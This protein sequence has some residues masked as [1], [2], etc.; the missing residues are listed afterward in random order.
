MVSISKQ[1]VIDNCISVK[2]AAKYSGYS[3]QYIRRLLRERKIS[4]Q[5]IGQVWLIQMKSFNAYY[6][7][8]MESSDQRWKPKK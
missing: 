7:D 8:A 4:G 3:L 2:A 1:F 6:F 5:K